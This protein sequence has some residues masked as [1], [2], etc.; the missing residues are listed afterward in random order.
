MKLKYYHNLDGVRGIAALMVVIYHIF[1]Y[2]NLSYLTNLATY[3]KLTDFGRHGV[4]IFFVLS[5]FVITRILLNTRENNDYF[6]SF[7]KKRV[8][9]ILPLYYLFLFIFYALFPLISENGVRVDFSLQVPFYFYLQNMIEVFNIKAAGPGHYWTLSIEE[10]FYILWPLAVYLVK[11]K[12]LGKLIGIL[13][14]MVLILRF[15]MLNAG[16]PIDKFTF[17][18]IDQILLG[19]YL[20]LLESR[21]FFRENR[22]IIKIGLT[23]LLAFPFV[24]G[25]YFITDKF[26]VLS[27]MTGQSFLGLFFFGMIGYLIFLKDDSIINR[28]LASRI[29]QFFGKISYGIYVWHVLII[30]FLNR[31]LIT[32]ILIIDITLPLVLTIFIAHL[33]YK[34]YE[35]IFLK[36]KDKKFSTFTIKSLFGLK[37]DHLKIEKNKKGGLEPPYTIK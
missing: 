19:A 12:N 5:G 21:N 37:P 1:Y 29:L 16:L 25:I 10:H 7:Y 17:T 31:H 35:S 27:E 3:Q 30:M 22:N 2:P 33:S 14:I 15:Y 4:P 34:Y 18:R 36:M 11:P 9:R 13:L 23:G 8:L 32:G 24:I 6:R 26:F 28:I 20:A